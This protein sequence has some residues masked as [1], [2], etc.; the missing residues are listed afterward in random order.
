M[1]KAADKPMKPAKAIKAVGGDMPVDPFEPRYCI[2]QEVRA[3]PRLSMH[4][5]ESCAERRARGR[6]QVSYGEMIGCDNPECQ[7]EWFHFSCVGLTTKPK[8]KWYC[9]RCKDMM[10][11]NAR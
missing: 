3:A 9:D 4:A 5:C 2:C 6:L 10:K 11:K 1:R 7:T 8:G